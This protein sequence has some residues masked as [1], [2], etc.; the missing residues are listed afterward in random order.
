MKRFAF[1][2]QA[3]LLVSL[4]ISQVR[5]D[6]LP[7]GAAPLSPGELF[8]MYAGMTQQVS[9]GTGGYYF[10][11][12]RR[13]A[14]L[15]TGR[16]Y[17]YGTWWITDSGRVCMRVTWRWGRQADARSTEQYCSGHAKVGRT[18]WKE[19]DGEWYVWTGNE[20]KRFSPGY[21]YQEAINA[22]AQLYGR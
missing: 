4:G 21:K 16:S 8:S 6:Q 5:A 20:S 11:P 13:L 17:G 22:R 3:I 1:F 18:I 12:D 14:A 10:S 2:V 7:D 19:Y 9:E 15:S